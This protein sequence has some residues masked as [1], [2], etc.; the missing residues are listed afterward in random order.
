[1]APGGY[2]W[3]YFDA[4]S[5]DGRH[6]LTVIA[7]V[8]SVF[9]PYYAWARGESGTA[10]PENHCA[11]N[12]ALYGQGARRWTM[13]E[14]GRRW[15]RR[16]A[17][18]FNI[19]PSRLHWDGQALVVDIDEVAVPLPQRVRGRVKVF[20]QALCH[21]VTPL[22]AG[23]RHRWGPIAP[24]SR[25]EVEFEQ[26]RLRWS[27]HAYMDSNEGDEPIDTPFREWD[28]ARSPLA[29]GSTAVIY[30]VR[31]KS[32]P[33]RVI[34]QR[35]APDGSAHAFEAPARQP[36]PPSAWRLPRTMRSEGAGS[37]RLLQTLEDTPF[38]VRSTLQAQL[39]GERV[40][41]IHETL[42]LPRVVSTPVRLMLPFR[43]PRRG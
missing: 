7:F 24:C 5:D 32:G 26:P 29:D 35:F 38:Y 39:L 4:L 3:W 34:A 1:V 25:I 27:G 31:P 8:G 12:V 36:L 20:P 21:F 19:G 23:G 10:D 11:I 41:A 28:W 33:D 30:D 18:E 17:R 22:D 43:M 42:D 40:T 9:S 14:R 2:L 37:A 13:T 6:G 15:V 16:D